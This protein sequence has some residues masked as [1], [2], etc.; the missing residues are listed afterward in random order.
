MGG[1]K[2]GLGGMVGVV[3]GMGAGLKSLTGKFG[4]ILISGVSGLALVFCGV[5][6]FG[7]REEDGGGVDPVIGGLISSAMSAVAKHK[8]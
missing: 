5:F 2:G 6:V 7:V 8:V 3:G 1:A 4:G